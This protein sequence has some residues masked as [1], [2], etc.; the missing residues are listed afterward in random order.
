[1]NINK[2]ALAL[3][4]VAAVFAGYCFGVLKTPKTQYTTEDNTW[5]WNSG[6]KVALKPTVQETGVNW[7]KIGARFP[8]TNPNHGNYELELA[9][10]GHPSDT[11]WLTTN[12][13]EIFGIAADCSVHVHTQ[14]GNVTWGT[15]LANFHNSWRKP[16]VAQTVFEIMFEKDTSNGRH[17]FLIRATPVPN[18]PLLIEWAKL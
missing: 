16:I 8:S 4:F 14:D 18:S 15:V 17:W 7:Q 10:E 1:M 3:I 11:L 5:T 13:T 12:E 9:N 6:Y 2:R